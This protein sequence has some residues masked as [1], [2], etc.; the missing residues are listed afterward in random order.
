MH[1]EDLIEISALVAI[2]RERL[3][4]AS[5][6]LEREPLDAY[7]RAAKCRVDH[8]MDRIRDSRPSSDNR[9]RSAHGSDSWRRRCA[10]SEVL[11]GDILVRVWGVLLCDVDRGDVGGPAASIARSVFHTHQEARRRT[12]RTI[13]D[14]N[15]LTHAELQRLD[16]LR[17]KAERW[18]DILLAYT[19]AESYFA[20][21]AVEP[22]RAVRYARDIQ[23]GLECDDR[24]WNRVQNGLRLTFDGEL[25]HQPLRPD[26]NRRIAA[27][28]M[29]CW[30]VLDAREFQLR[31]ALLLH[32]SET[33]ADRSQ[34]FIQ[35]ILTHEV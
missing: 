29:E 6:P 33:L 9:D 17:R 19:R 15:G 35:Q 30:P 8:W 10:L 3:L 11:A 14:R 22:A 4:P 5:K 28:V 21:F 32:W 16:R 23:A 18:S 20:E 2:Y 31:P 34:Q 7:W 1:C 25:S 24:R 12:L 26:L 13:A 27:S